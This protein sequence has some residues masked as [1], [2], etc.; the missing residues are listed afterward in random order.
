[1]ATLANAVSEVQLQGVIGQAHFALVRIVVFFIAY[2]L[3]NVGW[4]VLAIARDYYNIPRAA[5]I[6]IAN[7]ISD[8]VLLV[9]DIAGFIARGWLVKVGLLALLLDVVIRSS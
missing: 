4:N 5:P 6:S 1:M 9:E 8:L 2:L 7:E 3:D